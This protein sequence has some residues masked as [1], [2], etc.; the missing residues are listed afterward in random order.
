MTLVHSTDIFQYHFR[1]YLDDTDAGGIVYH[2]NHLKYL[3]RTRREWLRHK[4]LAH[5]SLG[6]DYQFVVHSATLQYKKALRMDDEITVTTTLHELKPA[7]MVLSQ[8]IYLGHLDIALASAA[9][10]RNSLATDASVKLACVNQE[11]KPSAL[12]KELFNILTTL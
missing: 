2:A 4:G 1:I 11:L 6:S 7:S 3:E 12:P 8:Q 9:E 5:Y 10:L